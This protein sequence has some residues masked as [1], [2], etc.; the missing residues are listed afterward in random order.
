M[1]FRTVVVKNGERLSLKLDNLIVKKEGQDFSIPLIDIENVILEG[2]DTVITT[3]LMA[4]FA[5]NNI[6][7]IICDNHYMPCGMYLNTGQYHRGAKRT[8]W[9]SRWDEKL[10]LA[11]WTKIVSQK[12]NNQIEVAEYLDA[13]AD[14]IALMKSYQDNIIFGDQSNRE[15]HVAK[16]YFN[17]IYGV[18]FSRDDDVLANYCMNYGYAVIRAQVARCVVALGLI[19]SLG[20]FHKNEYNPFNL[21]D[22]LMEPFRP[23]MDGYIHEFILTMENDYLTFD[24]RLAIIDFLNQPIYINN[25]R[26]IMNNSIYDYV[27]SFIYAMKEKDFSKIHEINFGNFMEVA[28]EW[29]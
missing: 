6:N 20:I 2:N 9:Q 16:V 5:R 15:G 17:S 8:Q 22:D 14:R 28:T 26:V 7:V 3:R 27:K 21:V 24:K 19:P 13:E 12:I 10:K 25:R 1:A 29:G 23:L 11:A 18:G 4:Q